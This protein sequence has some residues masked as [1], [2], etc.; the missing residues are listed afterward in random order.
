MYFDYNIRSDCIL[1]YCI[2]L[3]RRDILATVSVPEG[4]RIMPE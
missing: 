3:V 4:D 2:G 1:L